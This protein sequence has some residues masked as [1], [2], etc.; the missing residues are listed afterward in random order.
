[1]TD[2]PESIALA[3]GKLIG[4]V[5]GLTRTL[6]DQNVSA[7]ASRAEFLKVFAE[8]RQDSKDAAASMEAHI[9]DDTLHHQALLELMTWKKDAEPKIDDLYDTKNKGKGAVAA[10]GIFGTF[11]GGC[12]MAA[13]GWFHK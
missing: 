4:V 5:D 8:M 10:S 2:A 13:I 1:M 7:A 6:N 3:L 12:I 9:K 11:I